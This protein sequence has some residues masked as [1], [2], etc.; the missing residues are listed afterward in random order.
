MHS[1]L[2]EF[3]QFLRLNRNASAHTARAYG[4]DLAQFLDHVGSA[5]GVAPELAGAQLLE[6]HERALDADVGADDVALVLAVVEQRLGRD[7]PRH[8]R[9]AQIIRAT[10]HRRALSFGHGTNFFHGFAVVRTARVCH[11]AAQVL[12]ERQL[13]V[14]ALK[15]AKE[16]AEALDVD[17]EVQV[18]LLFKAGFLVVRQNFEDDVVQRLTRQRRKAVDALQFPSEAEHRRH[19][20][21]EVQV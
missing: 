13:A 8:A 9:G 19:A 7:R 2:K 21:G 11:H 3:L 12:A 1:E 15:Q 14:E 6:A 18:P 5:R 20:Y 4:S 16:A 17:R 10:H